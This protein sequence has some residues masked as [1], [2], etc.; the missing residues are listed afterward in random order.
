M[1]HQYLDDIPQMRDIP[2][3]ASIPL[4]GLCNLRGCKFSDKHFLDAVLKK[5]VMCHGQRDL[6]AGSKRLRIRDVIA[7]ESWTQFTATLRPAG[8]EIDEDLLPEPGW[9][10]PFRAHALFRIFRALDFDQDGLV[11]ADDFARF[12]PFFPDE[13]TLQSPN[14]PR[15]LSALFVQ[16]LFVEQVSR[17]GGAPRGAGRATGLGARMGPGAVAPPAAPAMMA[18]PAFLEFCLAW[19]VRNTEPGLRF[20]FPIL[21]L[22][23]K[24]HLTAFDL[25]T[26]LKDLHALWLTYRYQELKLEELVGEI[27]DMVQPADPQKITL[28]DLIDCKLGGVFVMMLTDVMGMHK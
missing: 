6:S 8:R 13:E 12:S 4:C 19:D 18:F 10:S 27:F 3:R 24:G 15:T 5:F 23:R 7:G 22:D 9:F 11:S 1:T 14:P 16:R 17:T 25:Y 20:F 21:D 28:R 26:F 2:P